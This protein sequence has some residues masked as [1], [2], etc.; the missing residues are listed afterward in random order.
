MCVHVSFQANGTIKA[1]MLSTR[2]GGGNVTPKTVSNQFLLELT[3][4]ILDLDSATA[5]SYAPGDSKLHSVEFPHSTIGD[6]ISGKG[7]IPSYAEYDVEQT[8]M[9][10]D[11]RKR[12]LN[13]LRASQD[14]AERISGGKYAEMP[15]IAII[16]CTEYIFSDA[17]VKKLTEFLKTTDAHRLDAT[18]DWTVAVQ[19]PIWEALQRNFG[20]PN[21]APIDLRRAWLHVL[22]D[23]AISFTHK[24]SKG[25]IHGHKFVTFRPTGGA[26][27]GGE[28]K[29]VRMLQ[30]IPDFDR[31]CISDKG[32]LEFHY[33]RFDQ[34]LAIYDRFAATGAAACSPNFYDPLA[35][36]NAAFINAPAAFFSDGL[37]LRRMSLLI[38]LSAKKI[39]SWYIM[40]NRSRDA[41]LQRREREM[42][43]GKHIDY[44]N[45]TVAK[46]RKTLKEDYG[47]DPDLHLPVRAH[48][49]GPYKVVMFEKLIQIR[50]AEVGQ[51]WD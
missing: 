40:R 6:Q 27:R 34:T 22:S 31:C 28:E 32:E 18:R 43:W 15:I 47:I 50:S 7:E 16:G 26:W 2:D 46:L 33:M 48:G 45:F 1:N 24:G 19:G 37:Q 11:Q 42:Y 36:L 21:C 12:Q 38:G 44:A 51:C 4:I 35:N 49:L 8:G 25:Y 20:L 13:L 39:A 30:P 3:R 23:R 41:A 10:Y 17:D 5:A 29:P 14:V 9:N